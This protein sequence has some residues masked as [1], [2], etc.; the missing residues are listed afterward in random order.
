MTEGSHL[1]GRIVR[2]Q[3]Q[4]ANLKRGDRPNSWYDPAAITIVPGLTLDPTG[5]H[6]LLDDGT[7]LEDVHNENHVTSKFRGENGIS[8]GF[9]SH[10]GAMRDRFGDHLTDGIAGENILIACDDSHSLQTLAPN[11]VAVN[12]DG[13]V[14]FVEVEAATPCVEFSKF[15]MTFPNE[16]KPDRSVTEALQFLSYGMR[17]FYASVRDAGTLRVG[18]LVY[19]TP[20]IPGTDATPA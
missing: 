7:V 6:G 20:T 2:L 4:T 16:R 10:Y 1:I 17:G 8:I 12:D 14:E 19:R 18:D 11:L 15:C 3:V 13:A 5:V 9:T